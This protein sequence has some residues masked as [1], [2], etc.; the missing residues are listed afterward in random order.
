MQSQTGLRH[1]MW[2]GITDKH[3]RRLWVELY[4]MCNL[5]AIIKYYISSSHTLFCETY[6]ETYRKRN[7]EKKI[8]NLL[9]WKIPLRP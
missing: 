1:L 7:S 5:K 9:C 3:K 4:T 2:Q 6:S 8:R